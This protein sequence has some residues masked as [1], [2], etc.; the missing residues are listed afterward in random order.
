MKKQQPRKDW[1]WDL[2]GPGSNARPHETLQDCYFKSSALRACVQSLL[3]GNFGRVPNMFDLVCSFMFSL[4]YSH[5]RMRLKAFWCPVQAPDVFRCSLSFEVLRGRCATVG[6]PSL[7]GCSRSSP[8][9]RGGPW[10]CL[11]EG[12]GGPAEQRAVRKTCVCFW[13]GPLTEPVSTASHWRT[14]PGA[15]VD[16]VS[17]NE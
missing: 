17:L 7:E 14:R 6:S 11:K 3:C 13:W 2:A 5:K 9:M 10:G 12:R 1:N 4:I 8:H 15:V 16:N